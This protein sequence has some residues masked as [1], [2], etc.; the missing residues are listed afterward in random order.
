MEPGLQG[1]TNSG[2]KMAVNAEPFRPRIGRGYPA[3]SD[4]RLKLANLQL[5]Q[6]RVSNWQIKERPQK[7]TSNACNLAFSSAD[8]G[9][10]RDIN[11]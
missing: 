2:C 5:C 4:L 6:V 10:N 9:Y 1:M 11:V 3:V 7:T 8:P